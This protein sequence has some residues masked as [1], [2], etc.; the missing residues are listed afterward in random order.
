MKIGAVLLLAAVTSLPGPGP[1][2]GGTEA[3]AQVALPIQN[4]KVDTRPGS[5]LD[6]EIGALGAG[7]DATWVAWRVPMVDGDRRSCSTWTT[8]GQLLYRGEVLEP[9]PAGSTRPPAAT[10][11]SSVALEA[12][13]SLVVLARLIDGRVERLRSVD[14]SCPIDA[15]GRT[16]HVL[17][18]ITAAESLRYLESL[19]RQDAM[20]ID[21]RRRVAE[22][23]LAAVALHRDAAADAVLD[24]LA[25]GADSSLRA[26]A[27]SQL[28][29]ARGAHGFATI[30][31]LLAG[32]TDRT[33]RRSLVSALGQTRQPG[34]A[35]A[36]LTLA[37]TDADPEVR[38]MA[39]YAY[40]PRAGQSG[41]PNLLAIVE[42]DTSDVVKQRAVS[43][44]GRLPAGVAVPALIDLARNNPMLAVRKQ[45][46]SSLTQIKDPRA[47]AF[48]EGL[49]RAPPVTSPPEV[50]RIRCYEKM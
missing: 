10:P 38:A 31:R 14:D 13:T 44:L 18:N 17:A 37:R 7:P 29:S 28:A 46:V 23:A 3:V 8:D 40:A 4:G 27:I 30:S 2:R 5:S 36:L 12:G 15:N 9:G 22:S 1:L 41:L 6:R 19:T 16:V 33:V 21:G 34:T 39:V 24:R 49:L 35:D 48:L 11:P 26:Q 42:K 47:V 32:E 43:G 20:N 50:R 45:A 25:A